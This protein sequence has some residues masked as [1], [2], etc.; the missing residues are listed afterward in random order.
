MRDETVNLHSALERSSLRPKL[1]LTTPESLHMTIFAGA[2]DRDRAL[3]PYDPSSAVSID[4]CNRIIRL[5]MSSFRLDCE[6]P[7]RV[8]VNERRSI[9]NRIASSL[10][11]IPANEMEDRKVRAVRAHL[12]EI[13]RFPV[14]D[15]DRY[16]FHITIAYQLLPFSTVEQ[17][18]Y[19]SILTT[20]V[21]RITATARPLELGIPEYCT[22]RDMYLFDIQKMLSR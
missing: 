6:L 20:Y 19:R 15:H 22:F 18:E 10:R 12:A 4:E 1:G 7:L 21:P 14:A 13:Y 11:M 9:D 5:R 8:R 16:E 2:N 3:W 17:E